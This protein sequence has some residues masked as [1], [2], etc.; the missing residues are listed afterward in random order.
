MRRANFKQNRS[1]SLILF[2]FYLSVERKTHN[3]IIFDHNIKL[4]VIIMLTKMLFKVLREITETIS[5]SKTK[6]FWTS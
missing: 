5:L 1:P 6:V 4:P 3:R 2:E